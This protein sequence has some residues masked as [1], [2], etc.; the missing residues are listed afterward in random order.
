MSNSIVQNQRGAT[1]NALR[2]WKAAQAFA[3]GATPAGSSKE[4]GEVF[5]CPE[6]GRLPDF[7]FDALT[8]D[9]VAFQVWVGSDPLNNSNAAV[10]GEASPALVFPANTL[11]RVAAHVIVANDDTVGFIGVQ[12]L[13]LGSA[14]A[15]T[16]VPAFV[17]PYS[18]RATFSSG[19]ASRV[20]AQS[21]PEFTIVATAVATG[22]Y[23]I[24]LPASNQANVSC[25]CDMAANTVASEATHAQINTFTTSTG[26][27]EIR[28]YGDATPALNAPADTTVLHAIAMVRETNGKL[29]RHTQDSADTA[30]TLLKFGINTSPTPDNLKLEVTG[31]TSAELRWSGAI[32]IGE[33]IPIAFRTQV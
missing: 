25:G 24:A 6:L 18:L 26:A 31:I 1:T 8:D 27:G 16:L 15:P 3:G 14:T 10:N 22:R 13:V 23:T 2:K 21:T 7:T 19:A 32:W 5:A 28:F 4:I 17:N 30:D 9:A 12:G 11:T 33:R 20:A 29:I